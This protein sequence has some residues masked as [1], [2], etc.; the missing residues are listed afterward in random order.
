MFDW[1]E[2]PA[3]VANLLLDAGAGTSWPAKHP[4]ASTEVGLLR[5]A[6]LMMRPV[7]EQCQQGRMILISPPLLLESL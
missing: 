1:S 6:D 5:R 3:P 7:F 4:D 2:L